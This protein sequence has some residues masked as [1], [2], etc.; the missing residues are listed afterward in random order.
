MNQKFLPSQPSRPSGRLAG[1][2]SPPFS[3]RCGGSTGLTLEK[4]LPEASHV[5]GGL[6]RVAMVPSTPETCAILPIIAW[7]FCLKILRNQENFREIFAVSADLSYK[8]LRSF[9]D[10][11]KYRREVCWS[12]YGSSALAV[13][14]CAQRCSK[15]LRKEVN[16]P[17]HKSVDYRA[18]S[19]MML[20]LCGNSAEI[21]WTRLWRYSMK[22]SR[23]ILQFAIFVGE[24]QVVTNLA[25]NSLAQRVAEATAN[26]CLLFWR[27]LH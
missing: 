14:F 5:T 16:L 15:W 27:Q 21:S 23:K 20:R 25:Q 18:S 26:R 11:S 4:G 19:S 3:P 12:T 22:V 7:G 9:L 1:R 10:S 8:I 17:S 24:V 2:R 6:K 13:F